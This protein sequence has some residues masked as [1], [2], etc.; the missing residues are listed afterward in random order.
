M[1]IAPN[2]P[3]LLPS[4]STFVKDF[5]VSYFY[6]GST[7]YTS[8]DKSYQVRVVNH[9]QP[10]WIIA[11][12][13]VSIATIILPLIGLYFVAKAFFDRSGKE[14]IKLEKGQLPQALLPH[15]AKQDP[16]P[17]PLPEKIYPAKT[18]EEQEVMIAWHRLQQQKIQKGKMKNL[19]F[20]GVF[21]SVE[22]AIALGGTKKDILK[23]CMLIA[24]W[25]GSE[26][27]EQFQKAI[28]LFHQFMDKGTN[29]K[30]NEALWNF[31]VTI[32]ETIPVL[33][34][35]LEGLNE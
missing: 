16:L 34:K 11:L 14:F 33:E 35:L 2:I 30:I 20:L 17:E 24:Q 32:E 27:I 13:V 26:D 28:D 12:K 29:E 22:K 31:P 19:M 21:K 15:Q 18:K 7:W 5:F 1:K 10:P 9:Q 4:D 25:L 3:I 8:V 6:Y 23:H